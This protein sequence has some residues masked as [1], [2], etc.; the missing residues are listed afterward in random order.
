MNTRLTF[1][2]VPWAVLLA[3]CSTTAT[4]AQK[5]RVDEGR[6]LRGTQ[7]T[8][9]IEGSRGAEVIERSDV[10]DI[11]HPGNVHALVGGLLFG[12]GL[13]NIGSGASKCETRGAAFCVGVFT[14]AAVGAGLLAW[15]FAVWSASV[16]RAR[17]PNPGRIELTWSPWLWR[18]AGKGSQAGSSLALHF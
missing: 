17:E 3:A 4:I 11:D 12:Y 15:G 8:I 1:S 6:I 7:S 9:I 18:S 5:T 14:P 10:D 2:I 13:F 16:H